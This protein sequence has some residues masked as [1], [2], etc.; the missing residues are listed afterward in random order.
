[1]TRLI[2]TTNDSGSGALKGARIADAVIPFG[3]RFVWRPLPSDAEIAT[4]LMPLSSQHDQ[5]DESLLSLSQA[6]R[7]D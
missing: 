2:L 3:Y 5:V 6:S 1:M 4:S 7:R